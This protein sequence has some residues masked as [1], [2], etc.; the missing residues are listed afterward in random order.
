MDI[1]MSLGHF[2]AVVV[3]YLVIFPDCHINIAREVVTV[4]ISFVI[5]A[6]LVACSSSK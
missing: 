2:V 3:Y 5:C 4:I 1:S 6:I